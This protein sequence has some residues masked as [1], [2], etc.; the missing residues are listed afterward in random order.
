MISMND[1]E[2]D[3][4]C[5]NTNEVLPEIRPKSY[6]FID[7]KENAFRKKKLESDGECESCKK[8]TLKKALSLVR[9]DGHP[10][11]FSFLWDFRKFF[12]RQK[13]SANFPSKRMTNNNALNDGVET[14]DEMKL[15]NDQIL[16]MRNKSHSRTY[17]DGK[18]LFQKYKRTAKRRSTNK[19]IFSPMEKLRDKRTKAFVKQAVTENM[20]LR[21]ENITNT[22]MLTT[23]KR[24]QIDQTG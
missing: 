17:Y 10:K 23:M 1:N 18:G 7:T 4:Q 15:F 12:T 8:K 16:S 20:K 22:K 5:D 11:T 9:L 13:S 6:S 24:C 14:N 3:K 2:F 21:G 19:R